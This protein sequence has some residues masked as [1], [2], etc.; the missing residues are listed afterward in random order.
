MSP[1]KVKQKLKSIKSIRLEIS[2][3]DEQIARMAATAE[4][5]GGF[6]EGGMGGGTGGNKQ[7]ELLNRMLELQERLQQRRIDLIEAETAA[8]NLLNLFRPEESQYR[9]LL[10]Y[11]FILCKTQEETADL[12]HYHWRWLQQ[13]EW[14]ACRIIAKRA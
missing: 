1:K 13:K 12:M 5:S 7:E 10:R 9:A 14:D 8:E 2:A 3:L 4:Y 11:R 6:K